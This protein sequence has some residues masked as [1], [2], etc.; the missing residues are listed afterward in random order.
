MYID[1]LISRHKITKNSSALDESQIV[2]YKKQLALSI[3]MHNKNRAAF[4]MDRVG[5]GH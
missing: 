5:G 3:F 2:Q 4:D 1:A